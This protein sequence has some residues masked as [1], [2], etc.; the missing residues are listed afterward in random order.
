MIVGWRILVAEVVVIVA[1]I[2]SRKEWKKVQ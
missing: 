1:G 2:G